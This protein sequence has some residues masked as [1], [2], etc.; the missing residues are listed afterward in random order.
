[1]GEVE[2]VQ[3][4]KDVMLERDA[5][6]EDSEQPKP[7]VVHIPRVA[8]RTITGPANLQNQRAIDW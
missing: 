7:V 1:M 5:S 3:G 2:E 4:R 8:A 6:V